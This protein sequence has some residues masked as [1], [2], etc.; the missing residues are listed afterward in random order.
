MEME[1]NIQRPRDSSCDTL[2][3]ENRYW[4]GHCCSARHPATPCPAR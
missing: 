3:T 1:A 2:V 4:Q